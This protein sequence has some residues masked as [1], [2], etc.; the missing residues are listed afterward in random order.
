MP[1][2]AL[3]QIAA[4]ADRDANL[5]AAVE[6]IRR[7]AADGAELVCFPEM[8]FG[9]FFPQYRADPRYFDWA[10]PVPGPTV[11][12]L[13]SVARENRIGIVPNL[14]E[15]ASPGEYYNCS[16][17]IGTDGT[18]LG[19]SRMAHIAEAPFFNEKFYYR[20]GNGGFRVY[21]TAGTRLGVAICY[22]RHYPEQLRILGLRGCEILMV[23]LAAVSR[24]Q[25]SMFEMELQVASFQNQYFS[26][27]VN[28]VGQEEEMEFIGRSFATDPY[29]NV[30]A[31]LADG[32]PDMQIIDIDTSVIDT[33]R[34]VIPH[35]RDRRAELYGA[36]AR[37]PSDDD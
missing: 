20:P 36:I 31:R 5:D 25:W 10:E 18:L 17:V 30:I 29:G 11:E 7:A 32:Q 27:V 24:E 12:R 26:V 37:I 8:G 34:R 3:A 21:D 6:L 2:V 23:P 33:A 22:D 15:R 16:P 19:R 9:R 4:S 14:F 28:R 1:R 35:L 13:Q